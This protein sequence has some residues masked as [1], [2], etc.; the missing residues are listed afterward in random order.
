[1]SWDFDVKHGYVNEFSGG[2]TLGK[3][4]S[5]H[6]FKLKGKTVAEDYSIKYVQKGVECYKIDGQQRIVNPGQFLLV[7]PDQK[8]EIEINS[9]KKTEGFCIFINPDRIDLFQNSSAIGNT[10]FPD[11]PINC[12]EIYTQTLI[13]AIS[14]FKNKNNTE[15]LLMESVS[16]LSSFIRKA[17]DSLLE[18]RAKK[19][20]TKL[21]L[22]EKL[23]RSK[24]YIE[25]NISNPIKLQDMAS[26]AHL[27]TFHYQRV[28]KAFHGITPTQY[29][30]YIRL[31]K[32]KDLIENQMDIESVAILCGFQDIKYLRKC[33]KNFMNS[34]N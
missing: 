8:L 20:V 24:R 31:S 25:D 22:W 32:A 28:F 19:D 29:L 6:L 10:F 13:H 15:K 30:Q 4:N 16:F 26:K 14:D 34:Q 1:M 33:L 9:E 11:F 17:S 3:I 5:S 7:K 12:N 23:E 21:C 2:N 27:S 18:I